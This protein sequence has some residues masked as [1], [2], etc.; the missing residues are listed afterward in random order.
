M[1][2]FAH[3][4]NFL[5]FFVL[6]LVI[7]FSSLGQKKTTPLAELLTLDSLIRS[8]PSLALRIADYNRGALDSMITGQK[9]IDSLVVNTDAQSF[10]KD[11]R[12][13]NRKPNLFYQ[14]LKIDRKNINLTSN[15]K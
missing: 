5:R 6:C 10:F 15:F 3:V 9:P 7:G 8:A 11:L 13:G 4:R 12:D 1:A 2:T 14:G